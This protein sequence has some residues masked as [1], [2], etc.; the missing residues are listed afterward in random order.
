MRVQVRG[1]TPPAPGEVAVL[2][3]ELLD[4]WNDEAPALSPV[5]SSAIMHCRFEAIHL[6][7]DGNGRTGR[8]LAL[9]ELYRRGFDRHHILSVD[10]YCWEDRP[11]YYAAL[12]AVQ[13]WDEDLTAWLE[14]CAEDKKGSVLGFSVMR[15]SALH[16]APLEVALKE[17]S[18]SRTRR[19]RRN[20]HDVV[21]FTGRYVMSRTYAR[22]TFPRNL[23]IGC[24][25]PVTVTSSS[26]GSSPLREQ[27]CLTVIVCL[28]ARAKQG[29]R[30]PVP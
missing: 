20:A 16:D 19:E 11:R 25:C 21:A 9:W 26:S 15:V 29:D 24:H 8:A 13:A 22:A 18:I 27:L 4:W 1:Y 7:A 12:A 5:L 14:Y 28:P 23:G 30:I 6:F 10:E 2:V 3:R 17:S